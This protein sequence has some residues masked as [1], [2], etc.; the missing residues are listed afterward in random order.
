MLL[1]EALRVLLCLCA[2]EILSCVG[3]L[4]FPGSVIALVLLLANLA[5]IG[6]VPPQLG[7]LA[8]N[9]LSVLG[10]L[11]VP[12]GVGLLAYTHLLRTEF[13]P[14]AAAILGGTL[15]TIVVTAFAAERLAEWKQRSGSQETERPSMSPFDPVVWHKIELAPAVGVGATVAAYV[16]AVRLQ[17][18]S[19]GSAIFN[20]TLIAI[21]L[22]AFAVKLSGMDY[23]DY[24][25]SAGVVTFAL[26]PAVVLLAVP[27]FRQRRLI[28]D[29]ARII[30]GS[31]ALGLPTGILSAIGIAWLLRADRVTILLL[32]PK[33][34]N[35]GHRNR[36]IGKNRRGP[37]FNRRARYHD[38]DHGRR[39]WPHCDP[40]NGRQRP[41]LRRIGYGDRLAWHRHRQGAANGRNRRRLCRPRHEPQRNPDG[42]PAAVGGKSLLTWTT[43]SP[44]LSGI[45]TLHA[46]FG[47][48]GHNT[49]PSQ[50]DCAQSIPISTRSPKNAGTTLKDQRARQP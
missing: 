26:S 13:A 37:V 31:L 3:V 20:P 33:S 17:R 43:G 41:S 38:R 30:L 36:H 47:H 50:S 28:R 7:R 6:D 1:I 4:P 42:H 10:M 9:V 35:C 11:F 45:M 15:L 19:G 21:L 34:T 23:A 16:I 12:T 40:S 14:I 2:G 39:H 29:S 24:V 49:L 18:W 48:P 22:L 25:R 32:A 8:D 27:L 5:L 46:A 44:A